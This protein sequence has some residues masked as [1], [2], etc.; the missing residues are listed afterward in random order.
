MKETIDYLNGDIELNIE[1]FDNQK[2]FE[3]SQNYLI[4]FN[5]VKGQ[6]GVKRALEIAVARES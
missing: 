6:S 1:K 5:E 4:D 2:L 3:N